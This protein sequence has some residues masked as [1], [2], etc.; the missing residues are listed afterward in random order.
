MS[1]INAVLEPPLSTLFLGYVGVMGSLIAAV[2]L[3]YLPLARALIGV[4][5]I[6]VWLGYAGVLGYSG[7]IGDP[8]RTPPGV[9]LLLTPIIAFVVFVLGRSR[10]GGYLAASL[11]LGLILVLQ[12]FRI[13]VELTLSSLHEAGLTTR[14]MTLA[15]GNVEILIGLS[16]PVI[17]LIATRGTAGRRVALVWNV[18]GL[19]SLLNV[20]ARAVLTAPGPFNL[21]HAEP[22]NVALGLFPFTYIPGFMAPLAMTLHVLAFR[23]LRAA[24]TAPTAATAL[25][26][27]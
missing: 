20:A 1:A 8:T 6:A 26:Y 24:N 3:R 11:P 18:V 22:P 17:A 4:A 14:L 2:L 16:A 9:F 23:A 12:S 25:R 13:G 10:A 27:A 7:I 15:G 5:V 19:L 21:I